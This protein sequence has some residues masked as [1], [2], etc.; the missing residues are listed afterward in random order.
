MKTHDVSYERADYKYA[1]DDWCLVDD[2]VAGER[3]VKAQTDKYLPRP[4][5]TDK[6][7][8][9]L[10]RYDA[11]I[12][13]AVFYNATGRTLQSLVGATFRKVPQLELPDA[14][15]HVSDDIDGNGLSVYQQSQETLREVMKRGRH[16]LLVDW[17]QAQGA[18]S[19]RDMRSGGLHATVASIGAKRVINWRMV[20]V[21]EVFKLGMVVIKETIEEVTDDGFGVTEINQ[22]RVLRLTE[23]RYTQEVWRKN[24]KDE[25]FLIVEP[26][27]VLDGQ[28]RPW[29]EIPGTFVGSNNNDPNIDPS[30]MLD[31]ANL[32]LAH[33]R[34]SADYEDG[35]YMHG[36][37]TMVLSVGEISQ[38][39]FKTANP[40]GVM[41]GARGGVLL[42]NGGS[43][44]MVQMEANSAAKEAM[45]QKEAQMISI[46]ARLITPGSAVKTATEAQADN[47]AEHSV[48][49][50][51]VSNVNE[52]YNKCLGWMMRFYNRASGTP[53]YEINQE[54]TKPHIDA[55]M[56]TALV[57]LWQTGKYPDADLFAQLRKYGLVDPEKDDETIKGELESQGVGL[58]LD[59]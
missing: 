4:N 1:L 16:F 30:P 13:R 26:F 48:L 40:N 24:E 34:N 59:E 57:T 31:M 36:Q 15:S 42:G 17:P 37:G 11:Y 39:E 14:I 46:G 43:A 55:Q 49:S 28:G 38:E 8:E 29:D 21:G 27:L 9:N 19:V 18:A 45:D 25:F 53:L 50:L 44:D 33:Y 3:A 6:S 52:A 56:L 54:F 35:V 20:K 7:K 58:G 41:L 10:S 51:A 22:Y 12:K 47:E 23:G 5:E 32:N 2:V